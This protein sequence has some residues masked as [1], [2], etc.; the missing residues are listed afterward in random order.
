MKY[1]KHQ[2]RP[3]FYSNTKTQTVDSVCDICIFWQF[4]F[5]LIPKNPKYVFPST[6][7]MQ[8]YGNYLKLNQLNSGTIHQIVTF[9][10]NI[11]YGPFP[12]E[13]NT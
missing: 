5:P 11:V 9:M 12:N 10:F 1:K 6:Y 2:V 4:C 3:C 8:N 13:I 7:L